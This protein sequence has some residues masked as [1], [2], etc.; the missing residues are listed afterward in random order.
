M[1]AAGAVGASAAAA[2]SQARVQLAVLETQLVAQHADCLGVFVVVVGNRLDN[3]LGVAHCVGRLSA[4][5]HDADSQPVQT[6]GVVVERLR[7]LGKP[8]MVG[9]LMCLQ[10]HHPCRHFGVRHDISCGFGFRCNF[11]KA[12]LHSCW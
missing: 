11:V 10:L 8:G 5:L 12:W 3:T 7:G 4:Q 9:Q 2:V 6:R 1:G